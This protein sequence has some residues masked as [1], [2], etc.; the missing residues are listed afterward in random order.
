MSKKMMSTVKCHFCEKT[1]EFEIEDL[2]PFGNTSVRDQDMKGEFFNLGLPSEKYYEGM[3][4]NQMVICCVDCCRI[5][6]RSVN[7]NGK[8]Q[9][10]VIQPSDDDDI[11]ENEYL[12]ERL[13][14]C[15]KSVR[16]YSRL[17][18]EKHV[19]LAHYEFL[20]RLF[21]QV[22]DHD[23][24]T[25]KECLR[26]RIDRKEHKTCDICIDRPD[27]V[28]PDITKGQPVYCGVCAH[29]W[30]DK[31]RAGCVPCIFNYKGATK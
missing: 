7:T 10:W 31:T 19:E 1:G 20:H 4:L 5:L 6:H 23:E 11:P 29:G 12:A 28:R 2:G 25:H 15:R 18:S 8:P 30:V 13:V 17:L 24:V 27:V 3:R 26:C 16:T 14:G 21:K 22:C 9:E